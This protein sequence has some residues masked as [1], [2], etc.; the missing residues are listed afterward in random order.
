ME[1][2]IHLSILPT[3]LFSTETQLDVPN[4]KMPPPLEMIR[5][6]CESEASFVEEATW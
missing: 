4:S 3:W 2:L 1:S 6:L 5:T